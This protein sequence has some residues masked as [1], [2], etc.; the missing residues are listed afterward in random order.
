[1]LIFSRDFFILERFYVDFMFFMI[2]K[3]FYVDL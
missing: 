3:R 1:M 2:F